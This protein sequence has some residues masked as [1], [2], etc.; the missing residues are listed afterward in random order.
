MERL[1]D[2][3]TAIETIRRHRA[4]AAD[5]GLDAEAPLV[6]DAVVRQLAIIGEA[7]AHLS[8]GTYA[9]H[10]GVPWRDVKGMRLHL[11]HGYHR[12]S[13]RIVL[14]TVEDDLEPVRVAAVEELKRSR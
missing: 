13:A 10:P 5:L 2:I 7:A 12:V 6:I 11:D 3:V 8:D 9:R 1:Q 14:N 4:D